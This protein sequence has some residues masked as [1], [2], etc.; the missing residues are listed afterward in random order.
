LL[1]WRASALGWRIC[2]CEI[3]TGDSAAK[4]PIDLFRTG[5]ALARDLL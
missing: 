1:P 4:L 3:S 2:S 5:F